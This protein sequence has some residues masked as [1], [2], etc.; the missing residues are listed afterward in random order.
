MEISL[1]FHVVGLVLWLGGLMIVTLCL[2]IF[3]QE[4]PAEAESG[5]NQFRVKIS[6]I[7]WGFSVA[8]AAISLVSGV[9][10]FLARGSAYYM[11]QGWFHGKLT[12]VLIL[13]VVTFLVAGEVK[14]IRRGEVLS[15]G[16]VR[17]LHIASSVCLVLIV[18]LTLIGR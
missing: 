13:F 1:G 5:L 8:G 18:F 15:P 12:L 9:Y 3:C 17:W 4:F 11:K 16:K 6:R 7:F 2:K 14:K 10:Q